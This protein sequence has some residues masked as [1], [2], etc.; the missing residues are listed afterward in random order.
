MTTQHMLYVV[1][2]GA[3]PAPHVGHLVNLAHQHHWQ[4][5]IIATPAGLTFLDTAALEQQTRNP[6]RSQYRTP[7]DRQRSLPADAVICAPATYNTINKW[8]LGVSDTY[9]LGVLAE[10]TGLG[11][12]TVVLPFVN[13]ALA[14]RQPFQHAV[15]ALR[16]EGVHVL[17]GPGQFQPHPPGTGDTHTP[18]FPWALALAEAEHLSKS[19]TV[20]P[21]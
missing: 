13:T 4:V 5:Q 17:L 18:T 10:C 8:A 14:T 6:I 21:A 11:I 20:D 7:G 3:G 16:H 12:P 19:T 2:C 1:V 15:T 9:A